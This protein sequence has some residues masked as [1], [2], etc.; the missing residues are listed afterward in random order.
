MS[1]SFVSPCRVQITGSLPRNSGTIP[2]LRKSSMVT[3]LRISGSL[4]CASFRL[5]VKPMDDS[6]FRRCLMMSSRSGKA[7]PQIKRILRVFTVAR[8][9]M[10]FLEFAPTGTSMSDP[11]SS[12]SIP[13]CTDSPLTSLE[14]VFF[15]L[16]ILS[17][18]SIKT[19]PCSAFSISF[20]AAARSLETTLSM[21]S[22]M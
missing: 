2:Y 11:S 16:A 4:S 20:P 15:F 5:E 10:A 12:F 22:P 21:S 18:S 19:M 14:V 9:T 7:P 17:I 6:L 3:L 1:I 8:G 13:C